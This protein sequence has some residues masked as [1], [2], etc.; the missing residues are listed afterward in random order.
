M[1]ENS[2][3]PVFDFE[4]NYNFE[5]KDVIIIANDSAL[6]SLLDQIQGLLERKTP[7]SHFHFRDEIYEEVS[8]VSEFTIIKR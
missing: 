2:N 1:S 6:E 5:T 4:I 3:L 7:Y 8:N